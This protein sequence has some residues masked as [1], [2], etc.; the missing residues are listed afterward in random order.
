M[1]QSSRKK[2][3]DPSAINRSIIRLAHEI[4]ERNNEVYES[5]L[6]V[7]INRGETLSKLYQS[8]IKKI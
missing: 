7:I 8:N 4:L 6:I 2:I 5:N 3:L 1:Q